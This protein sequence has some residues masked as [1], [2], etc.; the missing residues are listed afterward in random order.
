MRAIR[1]GGRRRAS[2]GGLFSD[3][4]DAT[5]DYADDWIDRF[6]DFEYDL[7]D[8][9][10]DVVEDRDY[11]YDGPRY[12]Q[13]LPERARPEAAKEIL[14]DASL[15]ELAAKVESLAKMVEKVAKAQHA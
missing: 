2:L 1:R 6:D 11:V 12:R 7:R 13:P 8:A 3:I 14:D 10:D 15:K 4:M 9:F 5:H